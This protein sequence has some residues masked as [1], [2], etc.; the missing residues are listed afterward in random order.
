[1]LPKSTLSDKLSQEEL[2]LIIRNLLMNNQ[3]DKSKNLLF[4]MIDPS[5]SMIPEEKNLKNSVEEVLEL[6]DKNLTDDRHFNIY[7]VFIYNQIK[8]TSQMKNK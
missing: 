1:M 3:K 8:Y 7:L 4:N 2:L 6:E 5:L